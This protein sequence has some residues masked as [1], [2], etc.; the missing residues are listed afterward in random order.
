MLLNFQMIIQWQ[1]LSS[2]IAKP[3]GDF[4]GVNAAETGLV[5]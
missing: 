4:F 5:S 1:V 3:P 2:T